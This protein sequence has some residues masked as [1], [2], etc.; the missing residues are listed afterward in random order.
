MPLN[1]PLLIEIREKCKMSRA[2]FAKHLN[3]SQNYLLRIETK[4]KNASLKVIEKIAVKTGLSLDRLIVLADGEEGP[5][6]IKGFI[7]EPDARAELN[8]ERSLRMEQGLKIMGLEH[9]LIEAKMTME[10][11]W[12]VI[13]LYKKY[14]WILCQEDIS[15]RE[16]NQ[17]IRAL[18][19]RAALDGE[20]RFNEIIHMCIVLLTRTYKSVFVP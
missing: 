15:K 4:Q 17:K 3:I 7:L 6:E 2:E 16:K 5:D 11:Y 19:K 8:N 20:L 13:C 1:V 12:A 14:A 9:D 18:A 10:R